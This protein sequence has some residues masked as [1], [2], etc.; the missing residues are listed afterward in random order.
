MDNTGLVS[1]IIPTFNCRKYIRHAIE[2]ALAQTYKNIEIIVVDDGSTDNT[3]EE[4]EDLISEKGISYI[5][6]ANKG[7]PGA[8]NTGIKHSSGE[9]LVFLD[10]DDV[11]LPEKI[12]TQVS[13]IKEHPDVCLV[14][15]RYQ[16][17]KNDNPDDVVSHPYALLRGHL[18]KELIRA[19]FF[20][21][22][23]V[24]V[25][26]ECVE[27]VGGFDESFMAFED[28][29][30]WIRMAE[31]GC[32]FD[33]IDEILCLCRLRP[34]SMCMDWDRIFK[35]WKKVINKILT[36]SSSLTP[37]ER[38]ALKHTDIYKSWEIIYYQLRSSEGEKSPSDL[39]DTIKAT[40]NLYDLIPYSIRGKNAIHKREEC[41]SSDTNEII[42]SVMLIM[43]LYEKVY[44]CT[45]SNQE[46]DAVIK[47]KD[48]MIIKMRDSLSWKIT[49]PLRKMESLI[50]R[51][52][53]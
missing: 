52:I 33:Y 39:Q 43:D 16:Y 9:Y 6:Q 30:L 37:D 15:S 38:I 1:I 18:Y 53:R 22:H 2:S 48:S 8:R 4:I 23:S 12:T 25:K 36:T 35:S 24:L 49:A 32:Q 19:N 28:W 50:S 10:S 21:V 34:D 45:A 5:Y 51:F 41:L 44:K 46:K 14:Y 27:K 11:I 20:I 13:F 3:R 17:F 26:K 47:Q 7:L 40:R 31:S 42:E 29:D